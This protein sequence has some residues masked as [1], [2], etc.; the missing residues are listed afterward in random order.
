MTVIAC[1][2]PAC[3]GIMRVDARRRRRCDRCGVYSAIL[4]APMKG[5]G[6][7]RLAAR[8]VSGASGA[9]GSVVNWAASLWRLGRRRF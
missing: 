7:R 5:D 9:A 3:P 2:D 8:I 6:S 4:A 1:Y